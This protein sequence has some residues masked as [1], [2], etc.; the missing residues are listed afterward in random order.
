M[1]EKEF[2]AMLQIILPQATQDPRLATSIYD[3]VVK[4]VQLRNQV[5][6][7]EKFCSEGALPDFE[8]TT[9]EEFKSQ[10]A[11]NFGEENVVLVPDEEKKEIAVEINL[12]DRSLSNRVKV[13]PLEEQVVE[14]KFPFVP[15][16][17]S[18]PEDP[19]LVWILARRE[20]FQQDEAAR[21]LAAI[22]EEFWAT[23]AGRKLQKELG[24]K[25]FADFISTVPAA[26]LADSNMKRLFKAPEPVKTLRLLP[27]TGEEAKG[28]DEE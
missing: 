18:L 9:V 20:D 19:G 22:E 1:T 14:E 27:P 28:S 7:F 10:L 6:S 8:E 24:E 21:A 2:L 11:T 5:Q 12:P 23:K 17:V 26:A 3:R 4:E 13:I 15:F 25:T 16:P